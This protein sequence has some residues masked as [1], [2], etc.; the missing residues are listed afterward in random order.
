M[1]AASAI[2]ANTFVRSLFGAAFPMFATAMYRRL[3]V[4]WATSLLGFLTVAMA[5]VPLLFF[6]YGERVRGWSRYGK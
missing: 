2:A 5:P 3:G 4:A 6:F 1:F